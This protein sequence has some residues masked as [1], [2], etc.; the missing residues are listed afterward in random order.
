MPSNEN[1]NSNKMPN[2]VVILGAAGGLGQALVEVCKKER[3]AFTAI[4]RSRPDRLTEVPQGSR[5]LVIKNLS[6]TYKLTEALL[7]AE[8]VISA[9]GVTSTSNDPSSFLSNNLQ[10][11]TSAM[12]KSKVDR[13]IIISSLAC[14]PPGLPT[15]W[16][17]RFFS[18]FPGNIGKGARE[19]Q[20][21][22][23]NITKGQLTDLR[24]TL[25]RAG[26]NSKGK[27]E[28]PLACI[29]YDNKKQI[30]MPVSYK[31]MARWILEEVIKNEF[32]NLAPAVTRRKINNN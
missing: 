12:K 2:K 28:T 29:Q 22:V 10:S 18:L 5:V 23:D 4:V 27:N 32:V 1:S 21:V 6:D 31:S 16:P 30:L 11:L 9:I 7:G 8:A 24:W 15:S 13:L 14:S 17:I 20:A 3:I 26:V 25:V 19:M